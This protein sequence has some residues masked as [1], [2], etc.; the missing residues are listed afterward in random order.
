MRLHLDD[1]DAELAGNGVT[2]LVRTESRGTGKPG[3]IKGRLK[4]R[5]RKVEWF[6]GQ[7]HEPTSGATWDELIDWLESE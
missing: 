6:A 5:N 7:S 1:I 2:I 4:I 3:K